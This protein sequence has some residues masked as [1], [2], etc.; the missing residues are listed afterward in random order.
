LGGWRIKIGWKSKIMSRKTSLREKLSAR[1][2]NVGVILLLTLLFTLLSTGF[3]YLTA[4]LIPD[5]FADELLH[6][7]SGEKLFKI[8]LLDPIPNSVTILNSQDDDGFGDYI[9]LHFKIS[10]EDLSRILTS[11]EY[12]TTAFIPIGGYYNDTDVPTG[13]TW[14]DL[15]SLG[16]N[17][18]EYSVNIQYE[19]RE[20]Y[21]HERYQTIWV[22]SQQDEVY[23][24]VTFIN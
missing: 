17:A 16:K 5:G 23:F 15:H 21:Q 8:F 7:R 2:K 10:P 20:G 13:L 3:C 18:T 1:V 11:E 24:K 6:G 19:T 9:F 12:E 22:N 14:W 4:Q